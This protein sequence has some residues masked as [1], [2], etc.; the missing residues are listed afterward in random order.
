LPLLQ[1]H[2]QA[3]RLREITLTE[4][5]SIQEHLRRLLTAPAVRTQ[6]GQGSKGTE[7]DDRSGL[8]GITLSPNRDAA[9]FAIQEA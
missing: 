5:R 8:D 2:R 6:A 4:V 7:K 3:E 9:G 1:D